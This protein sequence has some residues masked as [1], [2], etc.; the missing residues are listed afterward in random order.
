MKKLLILIFLLLVLLM[1]GCAAIFHG[2]YEDVNFYSKPSGAEV[3]VNGQY[4]GNTPLLNLT[5][6]SNKDYFIEIKKD[7]FVT[8]AKTIYSDLNV[9]YL[10]LDIV[11]TGLIGVVI[12][13]ATGA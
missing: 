2:K 6:R 11:F 5:L 10:V 13:A 12:D 8:Y 4:R 7:G 9:G 3:Y 1:S